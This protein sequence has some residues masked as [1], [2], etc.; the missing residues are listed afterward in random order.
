M[1]YAFLMT[2]GNQ[3]ENDRKKN[4][5]EQKGRKP[6]NLTPQQRKERDIKAMQEKQ[7]KKL[8]K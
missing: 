1:N 2:R 6:D 5:K 7:Q 8:E 3:R 4:Q